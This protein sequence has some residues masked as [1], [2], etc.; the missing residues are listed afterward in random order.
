MEHNEDKPKKK[1]NPINLWG[2]D[3]IEFLKN[4]S[5]EVE[6][7]SHGF[8]LRDSINMLYAT[9]GIGKS[10]IGIQ[11]ALE[12]ASG[13]PV[14]KSFHT[15]KPLKVIFCV[16]ERSIK[17]PLKRIKTMIG[18]EELK[19]IKFDNFTITTE[20]QGRDVSNP[21]QADTLLESLKK[22]SE[23]MGGVDLIF[24][25]PLYAL[26]RGDL[27]EDKAINGVFTFF[28]RI[29]SDLGASVFFFHH[30]NRGIYDKKKNKRTGQ[31]FYG[32]KFIS[33]LCTA[34]WHLHKEEDDKFKTFLINEKDSESV[35]I[36]RIGL[37]FSP[38]NMT[39]RADV[40]SSPKNRNIMID[41]FL[42]RMVE[43]GK[44]FSLEELFKDI[45]CKLHESNQRK[46]VGELI[47]ENRIKNIAPSGYKAIYISI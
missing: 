2:I 28:R 5:D 21:E 33:G 14:F 12:L 10:L 8:L 37:L 34:V 29:G 19:D 27:K 4:I 25:D 40:S 17:E 1:M 46:V 47:K 3:L 26:V 45:G 30:E 23:V 13:L 36:K 22:H 38:E 31:D 11:M 6:W 24:F 9:D 43:E 18:D 7:D 39:V 44:K 16:A 20:F 35:L 32:N 42:K 41:A 15:N